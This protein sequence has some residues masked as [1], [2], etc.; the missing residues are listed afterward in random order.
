MHLVT[1]I[2]GN[3]QT[4][5][6]AIKRILE[7]QQVRV[8]LLDLEPD[9][10]ATEHQGNPWHTHD[11][12]INVYESIANSSFH[13]VYCDYGIVSRELALQIMFAMQKSKPIILNELPSFADDVDT[14]SQRI[15]ASRLHNFSIANLTRGDKQSIGSALRYLNSASK[16]DYSLN[17]HDNILIRSKVRNHLREMVSSEASPSQQTLADIALAAA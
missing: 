12:R 16:I 2:S 10:L 7:E 5:M 8:A 14:F 11:F 13:V 15:I 1:Q 4:K 6:S 3:N 9:F 17:A